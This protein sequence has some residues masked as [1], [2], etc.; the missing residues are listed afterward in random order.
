MKPTIVLLLLFLQSFALYSQT[1]TVFWFAAPD[2]S[3]V[4]GTPLQNGAPV[5]LHITA[6][7][8]T[9]VTVSQPANVSFLPIT[10]SLN[11]NERRSIRLDTCTTIDQIENYPQALPLTP[12]NAQ[13]KAFKISS[14]G[15][16]ISVIYDLDNP[17][18]RELFTLKGRNAMGKN[19]F[20]STQNFFPNGTY[21]G[22]AWSGF[23]I[24]A[25][26]N[27]T[28]I[29]V[30]PNDDWYYFDTNPGDSLVLVL[31]AGET[32]AF[33][34]A[35]TAAN[36]HINGVPVKS[37]KDIVITWYDDSITKKNAANTTCTT[38]LSFDIIGDQLVPVNHIG[39]E[40][41]IVKGQ[42]TTISAPNCPADGGDR[43]FITSTEPNTD[44]AVNGVSV[45]TIAL[46]GQVFNYPV[47]TTSLHVLASKPVYIT[48]VTGFGGETGAAL[49]PS[50]DNSAGSE[51]IAFTRSPNVSDGF[52]LNL[53]V[54]N[55][56]NFY[57][58]NTVDAFILTT[59]SQGWISVPGYSFEPTSDSAWLVLKKTPDV[60]S[61]MSNY[62]K[63]G[64]TVTL[65]NNVAGFQLG[66]ISG[67]ASSGAKYGYVTDFS[68]KPVKQVAQSKDSLMIT[69]SSRILPYDYDEDEL[70]VLKITDTVTNRIW[71][72]T[73]AIVTKAHGF[74][75][76]VYVDS[77]TYKCEIL[78]MGANV[79]NPVIKVDGHHIIP[80][81]YPDYEY[82]LFN[83]PG[84]Y[85]TEN[86]IWLSACDSLVSPSKK[87]TWYNDGVYY[88]T[89][90]NAEGFDSLMIVNLDIKNRS[91]A[92]L[93]ETA[94]ESYVSPGGQLLETSGTYQ[95][96]IPNSA[97]C[98]SNITINLTVIKIDNTVETISGTMKA[99]VEDAS[100]QWLVCT[101]GLDI[102]G[103]TDQMY[104]PVVTGLYAVR[105][106]KDGCAVTSNCIPITI[107]ASSDYD[108]PG[109]VY[110][111]N[112]VTD[113]LRIDLKEEYALVK[114]TITDLSGR[115][116]LQQQ[117]SGLKNIRINTG[118]FTSG[119]Y[120]ISLQ[121]DDKQA[122][123]KIVK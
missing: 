18:N 25:T 39:K 70:L 42:L 43:I 63:P 100:Y 106:T 33:R 111:P 97:G 30:Y 16:K 76:T 72:D 28:R 103:A 37:D 59:P 88:D 102:E 19:F 2:V 47:E 22:T 53:A 118:S 58:I 110:Y 93:N 69:I 6:Q 90:P 120:F 123:F 80:W 9:T 40:Y 81:G 57:Q 26:K 46:A 10:F 79:E 56:T 12:G 24:A 77:G 35:A 122:E 5:I 61:F 86:T 83:L 44:I 94:C 112:P 54:R 20:V 107:T 60:L 84:T 41:V 71:Y 38:S 50:V 13:K 62:I 104:T 52:Q 89:I 29:V 108:V 55:V 48:H 78:D 67:G 31:N 68:P 105:L 85:D 49:I 91:F 96:T 74:Q 3:N 115:L 92:V 82:Y 109:L 87:Y 66:I 51:K 8:T 34:A 113:E 64:E 4:H 15:G 98:D 75:D 95:E 23:V 119:L 121:A 116:M 114:L 17:Y 65:E 117:F 27:N 21:G 36:R 14:S 99:A 1:D 11:K 45:A 73:A 101:S 32:F 7:E